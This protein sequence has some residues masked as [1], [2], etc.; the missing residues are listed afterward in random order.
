MR[1]PWWFLPWRLLCCVPLPAAA[2]GEASPTGALYVTTLPAGADAWVDGTYVGRTPVLVDSLS[3]GK[4][5]LTLTRAGWAE[6]EVDV[7]VAA[8]PTTM[9]S[10]RLTQVVRPGAHVAMGSVAFAGLPA[11][12]RVS[13]DGNAAV[14]DPRET[15]ALSPG[16]HV[17][18]IE[19][20]DGKATRTFAVY[21]DTTTHVLLAKASVAGSKPAVVAPA[22]EFLPAD[23]YHVDGKKVT[24]NYAG[25]SVVAKIGD[26]SMR[27]DGVTVSFD[28]APSMIAGRLYLPLAL[29]VRLS[30]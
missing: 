22:E 13:I 26:A 3:T 14:R 4:H 7:D 23:A 19:T 15:I 1:A 16:T 17:A 5:A 6:R 18:Q 30:K 8:G 9:S 20:H 10:L 2:G 25:H 27:Y 21:P 24:V 28:A 11:G 12:A 29:L